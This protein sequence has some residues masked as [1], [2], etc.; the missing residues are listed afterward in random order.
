MQNKISYKL[1]FLI[2]LISFIVTSISVYIQINKQ[3]EN[4]INSFEK[5]LNNIKNN[6]IPIL[7]QSLW[8]IDSLAID[9]F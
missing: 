8:N 2:F 9:I 7:S 4:Q 5:S 3:Y 1:I 6:Q